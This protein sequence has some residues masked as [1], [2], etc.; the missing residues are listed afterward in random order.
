MNILTMN[1]ELRDID[2]FC[3]HYSSFPKD[4]YCQFNLWP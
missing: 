4:T 2:F 1:D 3:K